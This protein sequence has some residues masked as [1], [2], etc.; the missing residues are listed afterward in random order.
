MD[1]A[2]SHPRGASTDTGLDRVE[3][4]EEA[5]L[6]PH[7]P[8]CETMDVQPNITERPEPAYGVAVRTLSTNLM[9]VNW[10]N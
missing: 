9:T 5:R 4:A 3:E 2:S 6:D 7:Q 10:G 8:P 1:T